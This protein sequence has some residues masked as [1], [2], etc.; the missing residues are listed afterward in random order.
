MLAPAFAQPIQVAVDRSDGFAIES[1][2]ARSTAELSP[3]GDE[4]SPETYWSTRPGPNLWKNRQNRQR[5]SNLR[6][7]TILL[8]LLSIATPKAKPASASGPTPAASPGD[9]YV[10]QALNLVEQ[11]ASIV[12]KLRQQSHLRDKTLV[13]SGNYWQQL[14]SQGKRVVR[15]EMQTQMGEQSASFV[16]VFDGDHLWTDRRLPS[17]RQVN[18]LDMAWLQTKLQATRRGTAPS[19]LTRRLDLVE[20]QGGFSQMLASLLRNY[21]FSAPQPTQ[22]NGLPVNALVGRWKPDRLAQLWPAAEH[23]DQQETLEWPEQIPHH[24]L[25]LLGRNMFPYVCEY[26]SAADASLA[27]SLVGLRPAAEPLLRYEIFEVQFAVAIPAETFTYTPGDIDW[28]DE[29]SLVLDQL[30]QGQTQLAA[31]EESIR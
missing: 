31:R 22:L 29:T 12:A 26:R 21:H 19:Q 17:R 28:S 6:G 8:L 1:A 30:T 25:L 3:A 14:R 5:K 10:L 9:P 18:R 27:T 11:Q 23:R 2:S 24:V 16:Q 15:W 7:L 13:G 4:G 20:G